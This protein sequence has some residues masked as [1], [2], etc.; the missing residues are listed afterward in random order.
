MPRLWDDANIT[1]I[2]NQ[3]TSDNAQGRPGGFLSVK[4]SGSGVA[5]GKN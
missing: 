5:P 1:F 2:V 3:S 4:F